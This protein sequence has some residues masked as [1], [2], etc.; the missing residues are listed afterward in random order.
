[1]NTRN[2]V[3][4][5]LIVAALAFI[6][7]TL[8]VKAETQQV[9]TQAVQGHQQALERPH[10]PVFGNATAP[11]TIVEFFDPAC[12]TCR[13]FCPIVK[14]IL[15][16]NF[17]AVRLVLRYA[18]LHQ[19]SDIAIQILE[20][21]RL[22]NL[23]EPALE[24]VLESQPLWAD[25]GG[26]QPERIWDQLQGIGLD[27]PRAKAAMQDA[28]IRQTL[29]QDI[30]DM[31]TLKVQRTPSFFVNGTPLTRFGADELR[32]LVSAELARAKQP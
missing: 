13:A 6:G 5:T 22:Q 17:G 11:V 20:A 7:G 27:I 31:A 9:A 14:D 21:A 24:K 18:P 10:A 19:G 28:A 15:R 3:I 25:H 8:Y 30:A 26:P 16:A 23:Y 2:L 4:A 29:E 12:E 32:S 1:M